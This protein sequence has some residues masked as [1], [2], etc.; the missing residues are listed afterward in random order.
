MKYSAC[1]D[2][3]QN[4]TKR[5]ISVEELEHATGIAKR[6]LYARRDFDREFSSEEMENIQAYFAVDLFSSANVVDLDYYPNVFGSCGTGTAVFD[7]TSEKLAV[8][9]NQIP[10]YSKSNKYSVISARGSSMSPKIEDNDKLIV[11][12]WQGEQIIDEHVY[13]FRYK[14]ELFIKR[15]VK[16]I[17]QI[18]CISENPRFDDRI[19]TDL[20]NFCIV[21]EII[22]LFRERV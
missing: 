3:L 10:D 20:E 6:T 8:S 19:I 1:L 17:D 9:I 7:E 12:H 15:L 18:I 22:G 16:N 21:G 14:D 2:R 13:I 4:L 5:K 11:K